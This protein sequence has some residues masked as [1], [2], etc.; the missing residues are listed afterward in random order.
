MIFTCQNCGNDF[1][2]HIMVQNHIW[3]RIKPREGG[4]LCGSCIFY[5]LQALDTYSEDDLMLIDI[6]T[7]MSE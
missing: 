5:K 1:S 4:M 2:L 3:E 6:Q 7:F